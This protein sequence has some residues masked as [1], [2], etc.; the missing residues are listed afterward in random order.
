MLILHELNRPKNLAFPD[1]IFNIQIEIAL[2]IP[3]SDLEICDLDKD[4]SDPCVTCELL[5]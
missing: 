5:S 3:K 4:H 1:I 2:V